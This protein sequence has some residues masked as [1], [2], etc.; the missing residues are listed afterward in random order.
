[1]YPVL[2]E[3]AGQHARRQPGM[4]M[5]ATEIAH[6]AWARLQQGNDGFVDR[7][8]FLAATATIVRR[9]IVDYLR[10]RHAQK[11]GGATQTLA[12]DDVLPE[13]LSAR[14]GTDWLALDAALS[15]LE[16]LDPAASRVVELRVFSGLSVAEIAEVASSSTATVGRQWRFAR[17]WLADR[18]DPAMG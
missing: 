4:T 6:E 8:H 7:N 13:E 9:V 12:I 5:Q 18:L 10:E 11:R 1:M 17:A 15:G 16:K 2:R 3:I 14:G